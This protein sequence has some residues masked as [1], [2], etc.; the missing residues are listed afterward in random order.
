MELKWKLLPTNCF[1]KCLQ[2]VQSVVFRLLVKEYFCPECFFPFTILRIKYP[3]NI[4]SLQYHIQL[5]LVILWV[6]LNP[7]MRKQLLGE[8]I[9]SVRLKS[10]EVHSSSVPA[11]GAFE[12][13]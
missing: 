2:Y 3:Q 13:V 1:K 9:K 8:K 12:D 5:N 10:I 6:K 4:V 7:V 11:Q